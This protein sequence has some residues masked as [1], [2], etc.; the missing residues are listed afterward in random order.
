VVLR[1]WVSVPLGGVARARMVPRFATGVKW[2]WMAV[3]CL[4]FANGTQYNYAN[5]PR[6]G[7]ISSVTDWTWL[8]LCEAGRLFVN[9]MPLKVVGRVGGYPGP[10]WVS[11]V[12]YRGVVKKKIS[13]E[14]SL[15]PTHWGRVHW[16]HHL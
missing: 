10:R 4:V 1:G 16:A 9:P 7:S 2:G 6:V 12:G 14:S 11:G 5:Q 13:L 8:T 15:S 3:G